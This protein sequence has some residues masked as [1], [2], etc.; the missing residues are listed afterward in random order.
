MKLP[1]TFSLVVIVAVLL[2]LQYFLGSGV[3]TGYDAYVGAGLIVVGSL[4]K[5]AQAKL[6]DKAA[7]VDMPEGAA[8]APMP[9]Q[10][11][12]GLVRATLIG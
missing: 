6:E 1:N 7:V 12:G 4:L 10:K 3:I 8:G 9:A 2:G 11:K 5:A